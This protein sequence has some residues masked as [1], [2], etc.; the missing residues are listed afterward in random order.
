MHFFFYNTNTTNAKSNEW[1]TKKIVPS[2]HM[3]VALYINMWAKQVSDDS[4]V[5]YEVQCTDV[6]EHVNTLCNVEVLLWK[7]IRLPSVLSMKRW[8]SSP[9]VTSYCWLRLQNYSVY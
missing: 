3:K 6:K 8:I 4:I 9:S 5:L 2:N 1:M 7:A